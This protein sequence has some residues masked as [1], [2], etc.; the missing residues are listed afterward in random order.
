MQTLLFFRL[1]IEVSF[2]ESST[3]VGGGDWLRE[4]LVVQ[5]W[6][7]EVSEDITQSCGHLSNDW[8][9]FLIFYV[10]LHNYYVKD[11]HIVNEALFSSVT[12]EYS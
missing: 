12:L 6:K 4:N 3:I 11:H 2:D 7:G 10:H 5:Y 8:S 1:Y 9:V